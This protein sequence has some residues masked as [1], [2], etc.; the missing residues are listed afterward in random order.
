M[1]EE[2]VHAVIIALISG[3][4]GSGFMSLVIFFNSAERP[5]KGKYRQA[6]EDALRTCARPDH[7]SGGTLHKAGLIMEFK[8]IVKV[9]GDLIIKYKRSY[10]SVPSN[11]KDQ[12]KKYLAS[13]GFNTDGN[14]VGG[15][16]S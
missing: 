11:L 7:V 3:T 4:F 16:D 13:Q 14:Y 15:G 8:G 5:E 2:L 12:V 1:S 6:R 9:Y 10:K